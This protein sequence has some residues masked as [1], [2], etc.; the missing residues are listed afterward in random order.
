MIDRFYLGAPEP[1]W[2]RRTTGIPLFVSHRRLARL[3]RP[4]R[5]AV[6]W[7]LDSGGFNEITKHGG[8]HRVPAREYVAAVARYDAEVGSMEWAAPQDWMCEEEALAATGLTTAEHQRRSVASYVELAAM[9]P[10][11]SDD[12]C[13][14]MPVLQ[15]DEATPHTECVAMFADAGVDLAA[16]PLVGVGSV[17]RLQRTGRI[18]AALSGIAEA[19]PGVALH[20]FGVKAQGLARAGHYLASADSQAWSLA[21]VKRKIRLPECEHAG[22]VCSWCPRWAERWWHEM[23]GDRFYAGFGELTGEVLRDA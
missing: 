13:P 2:L 15:G 16:V 3:A 17:C 21:A 7:A 23:T 20:G 9:W 5:A 11:Y 8:W 6:P 18:D 12:A 22:A 14:I 4:P 1:S 19:L 10:D